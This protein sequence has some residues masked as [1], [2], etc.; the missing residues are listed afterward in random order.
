MKAVAM[1]PARL[2]AARFPSKLIQKIG[3]VSVIRRTY[4]NTLATGCFDQVLVV[5][6]SEAIAREVEAAGGR[7]LMSQRQHES[8]TDRIAEFA[9]QLEA[10]ILVNVQGDEP[11][12]SR[13]PLRRLLDLFEGQEGVGTQVA[14]LVQEISDPEYLLD[15]NYVKVVL[16]H[17]KR[18]LYFSRSPLP[19]FRDKEVKGAVY[20]HVGVYAF[21]PAILRAFVGWKPGFLE[22]AEKIECLRFLENGVPIRMAVCEYTG[23][24]IDTPADL[25]KAEAWLASLEQKDRADKPKDL[26]D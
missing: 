4:E 15:P 19:Y 22:R 17:Q 18:A 24:E 16:D 7:P 14:S 20:E 9:D 13:E 26:N 1:I 8:G 21:R 12:V 2:G 23:V 3:G 10:D 5:T 25:D 6:D 11:F